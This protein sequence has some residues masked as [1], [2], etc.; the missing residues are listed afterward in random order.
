MGPHTTS[1]DP[2]R[3]EDTQ[4]H[5]EWAAKDPLAR[6]ERY[7]DDLGLLGDHAR[8]AVAEK[9]NDVAARFRQAV[10]GLKDP[11]PLTVFDNVY[12]EPHSGLDREKQQ[13]AAYLSYIEGSVR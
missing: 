10:L 3:Y 9:A 7:L 11:Q 5:A 4:L 6:M 8:A 2:T 1:D 13:Y 12:S